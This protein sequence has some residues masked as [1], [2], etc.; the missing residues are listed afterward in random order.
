MYR[1]EYESGKFFVL[2]DNRWLHVENGDRTQLTSMQYA[3]LRCLLARS[4]RR[5]S[6][7]II[8]KEVWHEEDS[9]SF[10]VDWE[11]WKRK[12]WKMLSETREK[13]DKVCIKG[14]RLIE[15][16]AEDGW[17]IHCV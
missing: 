9:V 12:M 6:R 14:K 3:L 4:N 5:C 15:N 11:K 13:L 10:E 16:T 7:E 2:E 17:L 1:V 8:A